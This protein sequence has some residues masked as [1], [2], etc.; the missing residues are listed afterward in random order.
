MLSVHMVSANIQSDFTLG[1]IMLSAYIQNEVKLR[2][3]VLNIIMLSANI[4]NVIRL[5]SYAEYCDAECRRSE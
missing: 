1:V 3:S 2:V 4:Q 5:C